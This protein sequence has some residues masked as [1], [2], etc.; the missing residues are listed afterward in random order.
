[1]STTKFPVSRELK[2]MNIMTS[3]VMLAPVVIMRK[4]MAMIYEQL[5]SSLDMFATIL[6]FRVIAQIIT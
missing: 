1:M 6:S 5:E 3:Q 2:L 4:A